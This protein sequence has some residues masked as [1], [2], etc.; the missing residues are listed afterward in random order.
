MARLAPSTSTQ[1]DL[2]QASVLARGLELRMS[3]R[4]YQFLAERRP[5]TPCLVVDLAVIE[6]D[7]R[8]LG[9]DNLGGWHRHP[10]E[11]PD[12]HEAC[13]APSLEAFVREAASLAR[14][15]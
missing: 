2:P 11:A 4:I 6:N 13:A 10:P 5:E 3:N 7:Q 9:Y 1:P 15:T 8:V 14:R 12:R